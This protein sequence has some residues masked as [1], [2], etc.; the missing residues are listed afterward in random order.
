MLH[1]HELSKT[2]VSGKEEVRALRSVSVDIPRGNFMAISGPSGSG[3]TTLLNLMGC[4]DRA[5]SGEIHIDGVAISSASASEQTAFRRSRVGFIFQSYNLVPVLTAFENVAFPLILLARDKKETEARVMQMLQ[6]VGLAGMEHRRPSDLSGGQR[7]RV[8]I[9]RALIKTP[10]I[11]LA[12]E[13]TANLDSETGDEIIA[14]MRQLNSEEGCTCCISTHDPQVLAQ[15]TRILV[16]K[17]GSITE[18][19]EQ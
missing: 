6:R 15:T 9:A 13:P 12:D 3:K 8:A 18:D 16:L 14:L 7:Q 19:I 2:Y 11:L 17:D 4:L 5:D 10:S 1:I